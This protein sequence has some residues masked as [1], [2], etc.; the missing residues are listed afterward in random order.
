MPSL[1]K[2]LWLILKY[3]L[4]RQKLLCLNTKSQKDKLRLSYWVHTPF[5]ESLFFLILFKNKLFIFAPSLVIGTLIAISSSS[6]F[7]AWI[8]LEINL[9]RMTPI[10]INKLNFLSVEASIKYF[11]IQAI[12]SLILI[13]TS[14]LRYNSQEWMFL[15]NLDNIYFI[16]LSLKAGVA[17]LHFWFPQVILCS[18]WLQCL[19]LLTWQKI[20]PF[21]LISY[22]NSN[23]II[24]FVIVSAIIGVIGGINLVNIKLILVYSSIINSA[25]ILNLSTNNEVSWWIYFISYTF[26]TISASYIF[27]KFNIEKTSS[28]HKINL[29]PIPKIIFLINFLSLAG[30]PP[31]LGFFI[32]IIA[33]NLLIEN[34]LNITILFI[35]VV[36]SII[37]FY[38][39]IRTSYSSLFINETSFSIKRIVEIENYLKP[40]F[41]LRLISMSGVFLIPLLA[42]L[43]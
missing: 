37:S 4:Q 9:I 11:L 5:I 31:F 21:I 12:A 15:L 39:Y 16:S 2:I 40:I 23:L 34:N 29:S 8:G 1:L 28:L 13:F 26:I 30:L 25:W 14:F 43:T 10:I 17:P 7:T 19:T 3:F 32:K 18:S 36:S 33:L 6:W 38:F 22:L 24:S 27:I 20:A 35:L 42:I 41:F